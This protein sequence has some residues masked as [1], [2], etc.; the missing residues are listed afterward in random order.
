[1]EKQK[2]NARALAIEQRYNAREIM[3]ERTISEYNLVQ[4]F[5]SQLIVPAGLQDKDDDFEDEKDKVDW[6]KDGKASIAT[7][8]HDGIRALIMAVRNACSKAL[9]TGSQTAVPELP[10]RKIIKRGI[11]FTGTN[12]TDD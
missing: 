2:R 10:P 12:V 3:V 9:C 7:S 1:M 4:D 11:G 6:D 5:A 8:S